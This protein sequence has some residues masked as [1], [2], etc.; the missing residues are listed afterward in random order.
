[1]NGLDTIREAKVEGQSIHWPRQGLIDGKTTARL[2]RPGGWMKFEEGQLSRDQVVKNLELAVSLLQAASAG[3]C[4]IDATL[5]DLSKVMDDRWAHRDEHETPPQELRRYIAQKIESVD[6]IAKQARFHG[7]GLLDGQSGVVGNGEGVIFVR[8]GPNTASS[9]PQGYEIVVSATPTRSAI[10]G[11]VPVHENWIW[12]EREIFLAEGE[13]FVRYAPH[14]DDSVADFLGNLQ[15]AVSS[16]G[17][18]LEVGMDRERHLIVRHTQ[19]GSQCKF[20]G[21]SLTTPLLS[22]RPGKLEWSRKGKDIQGTIGG[23]P[24]FGIGRMLVGYLDNPNTSEL[25]ICWDGYPGVGARRGHCQVIQNGIAF[26]D[27]EDIDR[28]HTRLCLPPFHS[29]QLGRWVDV[30]SGFT[31]LADLMKIETWPE[32]LDGLYL[33]L[34]VSGEIDEWKDRFNAWIER[35]QNRAMVYLRHAPMDAAPLRD[36]LGESQPTEDMANVF[37]RFI[38]V[39]PAGVE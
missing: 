14:R 21:S 26:Q 11:G 19:Y 12:A 13:R 24:A 38:Q 1:M 2:P 7:R 10:T 20:K 22:K 23:E 8:G 4:Q 35:F 5:T 16:S 37:R 9:P 36:G 30:R 3:L 15:Q 6:E 17:L 34:S 33:L 25:A 31:A 39:A 18:D 32:V 29:G 28:G 27:A